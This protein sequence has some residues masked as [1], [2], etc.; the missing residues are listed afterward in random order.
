MAS[1]EPRTWS[2]PGTKGVTLHVT[3]LGAADAPRTLVIVHGYDDHA[4]R[5]LG[6]G[7]TFA[8]AGYRVVIPDMRGHGR[9]TGRR[10]FVERYTD[11]VADLEAILAE[12]R[13]TPS[14]TALL[15]HSNGGLIVASWLMSGTRSVAAAALTSPLLG[16]AVEAPAWKKVAGRLMSRIAPFISLPTEIKDVDL[17]HDAEVLKRHAVDPLLHRVVN[18]RYYTEV[19]AST[20]LA[21][22]RAGSIR[23]PLLV[24]AAGDDRLVD[25][26]A[27][28]R[29]AE[30]VPNCTYERIP[31]AFH[32]VMF[33]TDG[34]RHVQRILQWLNEQLG[35]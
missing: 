9:S 29:W 19:L 25:T 1:S 21:F 30:K 6:V 18:A 10:G 17:T 12:T 26:N 4:G 13:S 16:I 28:A 7:E 27:S 31:G 34:A 32:E 15:G 35:V 14:R 5:Y 20:A 8:A 24:L 33:E 3:E 2:I 23:V 11:Y 22:E